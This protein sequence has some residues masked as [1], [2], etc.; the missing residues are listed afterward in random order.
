[1][2]HYPLWPADLPACRSRC[3]PRDAPTQDAPKPRVEALYCRTSGSE[4]QASRLVHQQQTLRASSTGPLPRVYTDQASGLNKRRKGLNAFLSDAAEGKF[5]VVG[6]THQDRLAR[7]RVRSLERCLALSGVTVEMLNDKGDVTL[8]E[9]LVPDFTSLLAP[10]AGRFYR[11]SSQVNQ[12][13][14][15]LNT[16]QAPPEDDNGTEVPLA[17]FEKRWEFFLDMQEVSNLTS[18]SW[19]NAEHL[20]ALLGL[21]GCADDQ[22]DEALKAK[23]QTP[24][25]QLPHLSRK[26]TQMNLDL[27][28]HT[29]NHLVDVARRT[30]ASLLAFKD[31]RDLDT[32]GRAAFQN[33]RSAQSGPHLL[34]N[35]WPPGLAPRWCKFRTGARPPAAPGG[36]LPWKDPRGTAPP[37]VQG[38]D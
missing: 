31:L 19:W 25:V 11:L 15:H 34:R 35:S 10:F 36:V 1:M 29:A 33:N 4:D 14:T 2:F 21:H 13:K 27:A 22:A 32:R 37:P 6:V 16:T 38:V 23:H 3:P 8:H 30:G 28:R 9:E 7:F 18:P 24:E 5:A 17:M 26:R 20:D 12:R